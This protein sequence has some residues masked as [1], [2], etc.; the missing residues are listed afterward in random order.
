MRKGRQ[1]E[2]Q[3]GQVYLEGQSRASRVS[4][5][6]PEVIKDCEGKGRRGG[7]RGRGG[8]VLGLGIGGN[9][10]PLGNIIEVEV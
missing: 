1:H 6:F 7:G 5:N 2:G 8:G 4:M 9:Y 10:T 3:S